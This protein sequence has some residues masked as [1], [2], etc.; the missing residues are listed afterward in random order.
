MRKVYDS[1]ARLMLA[2]LMY[3]ERLYTICAVILWGTW[4]IIAVCAYVFLCTI[5]M[6]EWI[7]TGVALAIVG[8]SIALIYILLVIIHDYVWPR[9]KDNKSR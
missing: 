6:A 3:S 2:R 8:S 4:S 5:G 9:Q 1:L 7:R